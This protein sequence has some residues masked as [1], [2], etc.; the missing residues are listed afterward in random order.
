[1]SKKRTGGTRMYCPHC[2]R[3]TVCKASNSADRRV[4]GWDGQQD[5]RWFRRG[6][7]C[8]T[9][10]R[11]FTSAEVHEELVRELFKHR[12]T[13]QNN[14]ALRSQLRDLR[15]VLRDQIQ[16]IDVILATDADD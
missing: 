14:E 11:Y 5:I 7:T 2:K 8:L 12:V 1:M 6:R 15:S 9:C 3:N 16:N 10:Q 13:T 4:G